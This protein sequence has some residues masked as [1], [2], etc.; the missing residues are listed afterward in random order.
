MDGF[1]PIYRID[2]I[3]ES[4]SSYGSIGYI[5]N[6]L[7]TY[8]NTFHQKRLYSKTESYCVE[9]V[10][11]HVSRKSTNVAI[12]VVYK[13]PKC[14]INI[15]LDLMQEAILKTEKLVSTDNV[16]M[17]GN[18]IENYF[19]QNS[20][21]ETLCKFMRE[22]KF[23]MSNKIKA[24]TNNQSSLDMCFSKKKPYNCQLTESV[25]SDHKPLWFSL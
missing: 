20:D 8:V 2:G 25:I 23:T 9:I 19:V 16:F 17:V 12:V 15:F 10:G 18:F 13:F 7:K 11:L 5:K 4:N 24:S 14:K 6:S 1:E 21:N 3:E 22:H